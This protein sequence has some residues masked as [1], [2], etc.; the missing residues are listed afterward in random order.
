MAYEGFGI[1]G[2]KRPRKDRNTIAGGGSADPGPGWENRVLNYN[3]LFPHRSGTVPTSPA[4][5]TPWSD[6]NPNTPTG[7]G[8]T[9]TK[10]RSTPKPKGGKKPKGNTRV[11]TP[12]PPATAPF[13]P[14]P[15]MAAIN[16]AKK[17]AKGYYQAGLQ[18]LKADL[19]AAEADINRRYN[20]SRTP[21]EKRALRAEL[22]DIKNQARAATKVIESVYTDSRKE[23]DQAAKK[24]ENMAGR[25]ADRTF[26][27]WDRAAAA[28]A[29]NTA[30][31][32][33]SS[34]AGA[35]LG[36]GGMSIGGDVTAETGFSSRRGARE[37]AMQEDLGRIAAA[38]QRALASSLAAQE[39]ARQGELQRAALGLRADAR[40]QSLAESNAR[41]AA[42]T[43]QRNSALEQ[44]A[45][46]GI[47]GRQA[48][49]EA[50]AGLAM[51]TGMEKFRTRND[52]ANAVAQAAAADA[53]A[54]WQAS[55]AAA[56]ARGNREL[57]PAQF[58]RRQARY[59][60]NSPL[61]P[62]VATLRNVPGGFENPA[63]GAPPIS[64]RRLAAAVQNLIGSGFGLS[65]FDRQ[66]LAATWLGELEGS[67]PGV[68]AHLASMGI[69]EQSLGL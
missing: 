3:P 12:T 39:A 36:V 14:R 22:R 60:S 43:A 25:V 59:I 33:T 7:T 16:A 35:A 55:Q 57:T 62:A 68:T 18:A 30:Q 49:L 63:S 65:Q 41:I 10:P 52:Y 54:A 27:F 5:E 9:S 44:L 50:M 2:V 40:Q 15:N 69:T 4:G 28:Q 31:T 11:P 19:A 34:D 47:Q 53:Q 26:E 51:D 13:V 48:N 64:N 42:E 67:Y 45:M 21:G 58:E 24:T 1:G 61:A 56:E 8:A 37:A 38:E 20:L 6:R 46:M 17:E 29:A 23:I 32:Q 66:Q